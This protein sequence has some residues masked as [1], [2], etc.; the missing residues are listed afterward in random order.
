MKTCRAFGFLVRSQL[1][2][3]ETSPIST[4]KKQKRLKL[5]LDDACCSSHFWWRGRELKRERGQ[6]SMSFS[7]NNSDVEWNSMK[8]LVCWH[9]LSACSDDN[10][11]EAVSPVSFC[12]R[13]KQMFTNSSR[14]LFLS[15]GESLYQNKLKL[16]SKS[17]WRQDKGNFLIGI[18]LSRRLI[19]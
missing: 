2:F 9:N 12:L 17:R 18:I 15:E 1:E 7:V 5:E 11:I 13:F 6:C 10:L 14:S 19:N 8:A 3:E 4:W 16:W